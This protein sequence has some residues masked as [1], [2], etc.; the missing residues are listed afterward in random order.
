MTDFIDDVMGFN[1]AD[2][3]I[4][5]ASETTE[6]NQ[7]IYKTNPKDSKAEDGHYRSKIRIIYNPHDIKQSIV[8]Q[9]TYAMNDTN[10]FF[11]VKSKLGNND[12][13]CPIFSSWKKLWFSNDENKKAWA[14]QMYDKSESQ[15]CLVQVIE[16]ENKPEMV[17]Q[18]KVMKLPKA[19]YVKLDALMNPAPETKKTPVPVMDYIFGRVLEMDVTPGPDD[20]VHPERKNRE[21]KYDL[22]AFENDPTPVINVDGT[23]FFTDEELELIENYNNAR[24]D[25]AKAKT[26]KKKAEAQEVITANQNAVRELYKKV[27]AYLK[28]NTIDLVKECTYQAWDA[29]TEKRVN[30]W[31]SVVADMKDPKTTSASLANTIVATVV[32]TTTTAPVD[33]IDSFMNGTDNDDDMPF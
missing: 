11:M 10:G 4:F 12:R 7:T 25:L 9:V 21:I 26:D 27:V 30:D 13:T 14:K 24:N 8:K 3:S 32:D 2:L 22:C 33:D 1:P 28:D 15:W 31:I 23:P 16:D 5:N 19:I 6:T 20:P 29:T 18:I 17:G